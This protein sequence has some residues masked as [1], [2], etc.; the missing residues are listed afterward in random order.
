M[1]LRR[2]FQRLFPAVLAASCLTMLYTMYDWAW[3]GGNHFIPIGAGL[4]FLAL[5]PLTWFAMQGTRSEKLQKVFYFTYPIMFLNFAL[6]VERHLNRGD[7]LFIVIVSAFNL[8]MIPI[9]LFRLRSKP[10]NE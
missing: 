8:V 1:S 2:L 5:S 10:G 3:H 4:V 9:A 6:S 7:N